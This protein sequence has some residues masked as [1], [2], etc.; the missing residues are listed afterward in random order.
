M[1]RTIA[2]AFAEARIQPRVR[3][4]TSQIEAIYEITTV[5][6]KVE[7][8]HLVSGIGQIRLGQIDL[9]GA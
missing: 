6:L 3:L 8:I 5:R 9:Q 4:Q 7:Q 2:R 1:T